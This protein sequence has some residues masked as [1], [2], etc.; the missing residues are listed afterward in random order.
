ML[1][2]ASMCRVVRGAQREAFINPRTRDLNDQL[3]IH[4]LIKKI[5]RPEQT[6][7]QDDDARAVAAGQPSTQASD[8]DPEDALAQKLRMDIRGHLE[9]RARIEGS[10]EE[11]RCGIR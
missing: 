10:A 8:L 3:L 9:H 4:G 11:V 2:R 6:S 1:D 7:Q 5:G